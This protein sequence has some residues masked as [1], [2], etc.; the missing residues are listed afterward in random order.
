MHKI[1]NAFSK[2]LLAVALATAAIGASAAPTTY[3]V[4]L[5]TTSIAGGTF[6]DFSFASVDGAGA[7][8]ATVTGLNGSPLSFG[9]I[10]GNG[11]SYVSQNLFSLTNDPSGNFVDFTGMVAGMFGF[12]VTFSDGFMA[13]PAGIGSLFA[14][15]VLDNS[16]APVMGG[17]GVAQFALSS[18]SGIQVS[19]A[20]GTGSA[21]LVNAAAVPEPG[22]LL[23]LLTG[24]GLM[25]AVMRQRARR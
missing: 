14:V 24:L 1:S 12:N 4:D 21:Q 8:T 15:S 19:F 3:H 22:Q 13:G 16:F 17:M 20:P 9:G 2:G 10:D 25:G 7:T 11:T 5:N 18:N 6:L 23:L